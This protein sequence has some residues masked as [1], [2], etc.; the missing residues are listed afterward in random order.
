MPIIFWLVGWLLV[1]V[2]REFVAP[3]DQVR[4]V[5]GETGR[6]LPGC[7]MHTIFFAG[8]L[9]SRV[10]KSLES[11]SLQTLRLQPRHSKWHAVFSLD[12]RYAPQ[13]ILHQANA[14]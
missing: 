3:S 4:A 6:S 2:A 1:L 10:F 9:E 12:P 8:S 5:C 14:G 11:Q 13:D 7:R